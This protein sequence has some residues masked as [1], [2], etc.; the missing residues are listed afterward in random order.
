MSMRRR[1]LIRWWEEG[2]I[3]PRSLPEALRLARVYPSLGTWL[4]GMDR[5][6]FWLGTALLLS[7]VLTFFAANWGSLG[8]FG[9][10]LLIDL[11]IVGAVGAMWRFG[12][13]S[14]A[15]R[16][17]MF[18][19]V[20]G[21]GVLLVLIGQ[22]YQMGADP[23][24]L[25]AAWVVLI[26]PWVVLGRF[27]PL[28]LFWLV[29]LN[30]AVYL[31]FST[32]GG[33]LAMTLGPDRFLWLAFAINTSALVIWEI[34]AYRGA[35]WLKGRFGPRL[36]GIGS[37]VPMTV[38]A[39]QAILEWKGYRGLF[40]I[41]AWFVGSAGTFLVYRWL[42]LDVFLLAGGVLSVIVIIVSVLMHLGLGMGVDAF[43]LLVVAIVV[44]LL[45]SAGAW[46]LTRVANI[47][48]T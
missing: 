27:A 2:H 39:V 14:P 37:G 21:V 34:A 42:V 22:V 7:G 20:I 10:F 40:D 5:L 47:E 6:L 41:L 25:I 9:R 18:I 29:L 13:D 26:L 32:F 45:S 1:L 17:A 35:R 19:A 4:L 15:G 11:I 33:L 8:R 38:L 31:Y 30:L 16:G 36:L 48:D 28:W 43:A 3:D 24:Q 23:Y 12:M 44:L 46:W